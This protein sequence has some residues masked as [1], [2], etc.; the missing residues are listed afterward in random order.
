MFDV[1]ALPAV[2]GSAGVL[3]G[4]THTSNPP[5]GMPALPGSWKAPIRFPARIG[6]MNLP[7]KSKAPQGWRTPKPGGSS[8]EPRPTRQRP[9]VRRP[10]AAFSE[11][12]RAELMRFMG[13][14]LSAFFH[15]HWDHEPVSRLRER[16]RP[17]GRDSHQQPAGRNAGAPRFMESPH[18]FS[19]THWNHEPPGKVQ[20]AAGAAHSK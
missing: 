13:S 11:R 9:G 10:S 6:T 14:P 18:S 8:G 7:G 19:R 2:S 17:R 1:Q 4:E 20:S 15:M 3:A 12:A 5:A 16:R